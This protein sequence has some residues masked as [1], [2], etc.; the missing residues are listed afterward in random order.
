M[1]LRFT[2]ITSINEIELA[3]SLLELYAFTRGEAWFSD[4]SIDY[5]TIL[6]D[7]RADPTKYNLE[8][9]RELLNEEPVAARQLLE[10]ILMDSVFELIDNRATKFGPNYAFERIPGTGSS[11]RLKPEDD[12]NAAAYATA[13]LSFFTAIDTP[14]AL[15][16]PKKKRQALRKLYAQV[17]E[18]VALL[19]CTSIGP[20]VAWWT[21]RSWTTSAKVENFERLCNVVK[22][23]KVKELNDWEESQKRAN[24]AGVDGILVTTIG[25]CVSNASICIALGVTVQGKNRRGKKVGKDQRDRFLAFYVKRPTIALI[26]AAADPY[27]YQQVLAEDYAAADCLYLHGEMLW[28]LLCL[29]DPSKHAGEIKK[30]NIRIEDSLKDEMRSALGGVKIEIGRTSYNLIDTFIAYAPAA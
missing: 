14:G 26:G 2:P 30:S 6:E 17:F 24:D 10:E 15:N 4:L 19:A 22:Y 11:V 9:E 21:G 3:A 7:V 12:I 16:M 23:G 25:G 29:Y 8:D 1:L 27:P 18:L 13:W 5:D 28:Q 20:S